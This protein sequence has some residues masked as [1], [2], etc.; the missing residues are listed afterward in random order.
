MG[1]R[2][3]GWRLLRTGPGEPDWNMALDE[4]LWHLSER[5]VLRLYRWARPTLSLGRHQRRI[6]IDMELLE[7]E[8]IG[9]VR[10]PTGGRAV[11]HDLELTYSVVHPLAGMG[12]VLEAHRKIHEALA[13]GLQELGLKAELAP[14]RKRTTAACFAA[15]SQTELMVEGK[16]VVG[17]AQVRNTRALLEH[18][19]LP[20]QLDPARLARILGD[21][22]LKNAL[23]QEAAGL[24]E[25][26]PGLGFA[27]LEEAVIVGFAERFRVSFVEDRP[28]AEEL[29]LAA[30]L[31]EKYRSQE[32]TLQGRWPAEVATL[33]LEVKSRSR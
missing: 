4:A 16:K 29:A 19:S 17:S 2:M 10:R 25:F 11:L 26:L 7:R 33:T 21:E 32:W 15:P 18:G 1:S 14:G 20:L 13:L 27:K 6:A 5:P 8:G 3:E 9:L 24:R 12:T 22:G 28:T 30:E 23:E 31:L